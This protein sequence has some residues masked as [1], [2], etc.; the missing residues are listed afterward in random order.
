MC[1]WGRGSDLHLSGQ[2]RTYRSAVGSALL[3]LSPPTITLVQRTIPK[4][5]I[6]T[7]SDSHLQLLMRDRMES[8]HRPRIFNPALYQLS[9]Y[10]SANG[11]GIE[12]TLQGFGGPH[13]TIPVPPV[14]AKSR[15]RTDDLKFGKLLL[16]HLSYFRLWCVR[17]DLNLRPS[18]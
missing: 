15:D 16:Y 13:D 10:R 7:R 3:R 2:V 11:V 8:N 4:I 12:P 5:R 17:Q 1:S 6:E 14:C 9:Y 18:G